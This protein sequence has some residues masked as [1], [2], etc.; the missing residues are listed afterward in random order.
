MLKPLRDLA[1]RVGIGCNIGECSI[2]ASINDFRADDAIY[3]PC[4]IQSVRKWDSRR[5]E[6]L[7]EGRAWQELVYKGP[8]SI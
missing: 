8:G 3:N 6:S 7:L 2:V 1:R 4:S 5:T